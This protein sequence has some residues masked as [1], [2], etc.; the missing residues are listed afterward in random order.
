MEKAA[1]EPTQY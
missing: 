1:T